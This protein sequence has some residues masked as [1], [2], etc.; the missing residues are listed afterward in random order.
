MAPTTTQQL[1]N[2]S[3]A[4]ASIASGE[5]KPS[6][7]NLLFIWTDEQR[8]D[9]LAAYGNSNIHAPAL[10]K[11]AEE[12]VIFEKAYVSQPVCTPSRS[13]VMTGL[14]PHS[15]GCTAN[16]ILLPED[17]PCLPELVDDPDY[18]T[19]YIG[20]WH[21]GDEIF[22]QHGFEEWVSIEYY[23]AH[24]RE[25]RDPSKRPDYHNFLLEQGYEPDSKG[26]HFS[27]DFATRRPI[28]HCKP[29][30]LEL[31]AC[32]FLR[33]HRNEPFMLYVNFLEPHMPFFG[34]LDD[35]HDPAIVDL[36]ESRHVPVAYCRAG[37]Y[38]Y[39][40]YAFARKREVRAAGGPNT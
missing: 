2:V 19:A 26:T 13:T 22:A 29:K 1:L 10:N 34:P 20:K 25:G 38:G 37:D 17:T 28:E 21:L 9:T 15:S 23:S 14:W 16:N 40:L 8:A 39:V 18:R 36:P 27:R 3:A 7:P 30:F 4:G 32:D 11:L 6:K 35:E 31:K 12:S 5:A 24:Y 33:R